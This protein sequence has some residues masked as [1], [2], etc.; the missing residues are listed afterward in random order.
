MIGICV[1]KVVR[2]GGFPPVR[3][4]RVGGVTENM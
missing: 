2:R 4:F 3:L 1:R